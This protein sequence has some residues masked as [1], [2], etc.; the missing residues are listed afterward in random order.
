MAKSDKI[1]SYS[2]LLEGKYKEAYEAFGRSLWSWLAADIMFDEGEGDQFADTVD[3]V[4]GMATAALVP[5]MAASIHDPE[6]WEEAKSCV[7]IMIHNH[8][9]HCFELVEADRASTGITT[10]QGSNNVQ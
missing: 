9:E 5:Y 6:K 2:E 4:V 10:N 7:R 8:L 3:S 1:N